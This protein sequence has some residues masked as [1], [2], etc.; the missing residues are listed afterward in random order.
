MHRITVLLVL[1]LADKVSTAA[2]KTS[3][4]DTDAPTKPTPIMPTL[5]PA[6]S[7]T[8]HVVF[9]ATA[10]PAIWN[11][12]KLVAALTAAV[13]IAI[14]RDCLTPIGVNAVTMAASQL[15]DDPTKQLATP[16]K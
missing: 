11:H 6:T 8:L 16:C 2:P 4:P 12:P 3:L 1:R 10:L 14:G 15:T 7:D 5:A 13:A 9:F